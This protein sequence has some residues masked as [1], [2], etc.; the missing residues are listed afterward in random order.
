MVDVIVQV[1]I[2]AEMPL[3]GGFYMSHSVDTIRLHPYARS[4]QFVYLTIQLVFLIFTICFVLRTLRDLMAMGA[5]FYTTPRSLIDL[6]LAA[7]ATCLV[8]AF[9]WYNIELYDVSSYVE[10]MHYRQLFYLDRLLLAADGFVA[11]FA[12]LRGLLLFRYL[13]VTNRIIVVMEKASPY[14]VCS[15]I[16]GLIVWLIVAVGASALYGR[17]VER[18]R[19]LGP[20][21]AVTIHAMS[22]VYHYETLCISYPLSASIFIMVCI[23]LFLCVARAMCVISLFMTFSDISQLPE[24]EESQLFFAQLAQNFRDAMS[25]V[26]FN[27]RKKKK[28]KKAAA[29]I[30]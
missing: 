15:V 18:L 10:T 3:A 2:T 12:I 6:C 14:V 7:S 16:F 20:A 4:Y 13:P 8:T 9:I 26:G 21:L 30:V 27:V 19:S 11:L 17:E 24:S 28:K 25:C 5:A 22:R 1:V 23:L 29:K